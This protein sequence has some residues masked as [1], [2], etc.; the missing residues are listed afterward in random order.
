MGD[1]IISSGETRIG[2][3]PIGTWMVA[4]QKDTIIY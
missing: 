3:R 2:G 1:K 4:I